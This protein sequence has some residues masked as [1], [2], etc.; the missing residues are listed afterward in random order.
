[1]IREA[2]NIRDKAMLAQFFKT[3]MRREYIKELQG[4]SLKRGIRP[5]L[6]CTT[7]SIQRS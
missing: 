6:T 3:G 4:D 2:P 5:H 1:M 7:T